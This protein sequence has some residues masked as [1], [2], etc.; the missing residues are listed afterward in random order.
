MAFILY[1]SLI[2]LFG[3]ELNLYNTIP[4]FDEP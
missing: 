3:K 1:Q 2:F 4:T